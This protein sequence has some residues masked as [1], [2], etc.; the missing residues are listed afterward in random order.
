MHTTIELW[1]RGELGDGEDA[2]SALRRLEKMRH[3]MF[4]EQMILL[5]TLRTLSH[6]SA[7][8]PPVGGRFPRETY[9]GIIGEVQ[10]MLVCMA[11]MART[12][13]GLEAPTSPPTPTPTATSPTKRNPNATNESELVRQPE[14]PWSTRLATIALESTTFKSHSITSLLCHL[15]SAIRNAQPLPPFLSAGGSFPLARRLREVDGGLLS[16]RHVEDPAFSAFVAM[17]VLRSVAGHGLA[18]LL[19]NVRELVGE[20]SFDFQMR[21]ATDEAERRRLMEESEDG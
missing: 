21:P 20:I 19:R 10:R 1:M 15:S 17:E 3:G 8:E 12:A 6:F 13:Q 11:L 2:T 5:N 4:R 14:T 18:G 9:D 16:L 7:F